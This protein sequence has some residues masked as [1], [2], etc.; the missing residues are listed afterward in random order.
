[1]FQQ[2]TP[3]L[4]K[5]G[6]ENSLPLNTLSGG[7]IFYRRFGDSL[8]SGIT[9]GTLLVFIITGVLFLLRNISS[10]DLSEWTGKV[11]I[12][13]RDVPVF[14]N[15]ALCYTIRLLGNSFCLYFFQ[16]QFWQDI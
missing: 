15:I 7:K 4:E 12:Y 1:M 3:F 14:Y 16:F 2:Q 11:N 8:F 9:F 6:E 5:F 10:I 13:Y